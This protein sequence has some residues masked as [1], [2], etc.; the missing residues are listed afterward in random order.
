MIVV[1][2]SQRLIENATYPE[3]RDCLDVRWARLCSRLGILP[4]VLPTASAPAAYLEA[5]APAGIILTGGNDLSSVSPNPLSELRD[6]F[7]NELLSLALARGLPVLAVCR[8]MQLVA[9]RYGSR[10][11]KVDGHTGGV[12]HGI[13][14]DRATRFGAALE[15]LHAVRS[16]H[17]YGVTE[18]PAGFREVARSEDGVIE[19]MEHGTLPIFCQMW[20]PEREEVLTE[21]EADV[22]RRLFGLKEE[23]TG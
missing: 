21:G 22:I 11:T 17:D 5:F 3:T 4:L 10:V 13:T 6:T 9:E 14:I 2:I 18:L 16:Y 1:A 20:H 12:S 19:A 8:G 15:G 7:E 23:V